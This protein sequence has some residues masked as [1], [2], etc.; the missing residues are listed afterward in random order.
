MTH[1]VI[2]HYFNQAIEQ[3]ITNYD[4]LLYDLTKDYHNNK[5]GINSKFDTN[6]SRG[7]SS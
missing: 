7:A 6:I 4:N 2:H 5:G 1:T 3:N